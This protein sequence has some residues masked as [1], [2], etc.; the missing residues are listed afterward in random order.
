M[1]K[2][3]GL[4]VLA[5]VL[6][7]GML[8]PVAGSLGVISNRSGDTVSA[9][10]SQMLAQPPPAVTTITDRSGKPIAHLYDQNRVP[11]APNQIS[12]TMKA[13]IT[14]IEDRRFFDHEGVDWPGTMRAAASNRAS[15]QISQ[16]G[17]T[18]TQ[19][20]VKNYQ[21]HVLAADDPVKQAKA[22]EQTPARKMR[23]IRIALQLEKRLDKQ[24]IL[25]RYLNVVPFGN[26]TY[27]ISAAAQT[28]FATTPDKLSVPQ[29]ALLAG[30]VN[31][32]SALNPED[33][34]EEAVQ[35]RNTVIDS[36]QEQG[37]IDPRSADEA[38]AAPLELASPLGSVPNGCVGAGPAD[39][40]F[41]KYVINYLERAGFSEQQLEKGGYT[42]RTSLDEGATQAAK[43]AA[44]KEVPKNT[45]G[46]ANVMTVVEPGE[47]KHQV[48][49][50]V[51]NRDF[52]MEPDKGQTAYALPSGIAKFGA[53]SIYKTFT[54]AAGLE[55]G[56]GIK[57]V[58]PAPGNYTSKTYK[59]GTSPYTV[60]NAEG[61]KPG[62]RTLQDALATS[63]NTAFVALQERIGLGPVVDMATR[64]GMR[65]TMTRT[66]TSGQS[67]AANGS[68]GPT[69]AESV[70]ENNVGAFTLG[71]APTSPL[72]LGN[73][74][75]TLM[76]GGTWCPPTPIEQITDRSGKPVSITEAPCE[77]AVD[78]E[79]ANGMAAGMSKDDKSGGTSEQAASGA[80]WKRPVLGKT[81]TTESHQS[82][83]FIGATPQFAGSVLTFSDGGRPQGICDSTPPRLCGSNGNIYGGKVPA[84]TWY[85]GMK[86]IHEG[87][88]VLELPGATPRYSTGGQEPHV[89]DVVGMDA[90][91]ARARLSEAGYPIE[92]QPVDSENPQGTVSSQTP[93]G[94]ASPGERITVRISTG[95]VPTP[96]PEPPAPK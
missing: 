8:F 24:E 6:V 54:A 33:N 56:M 45:K 29:A 2:L 62:P 89:P 12:D 50:L 79:L 18:L 42:I 48:R 26:Q 14:S 49:A 95:H 38:R 34:P 41:C 37:R 66:N 70:L 75:A 20:Y 64:L 76:S 88:P 78:R 63:P 90:D 52:G 92:E 91:D 40:F 10:S 85:N 72:E 25:A 13:A 86:Q 96:A 16:G 3:F 30:M 55:Q 21:M 31:S 51:A 53:G 87:L 77:Q 58:I 27:G 59:N 83:G 39:G 93:R 82:A 11:V 57:D 47:D 73:V 9:I 65:Q 5:G 35:R 1:V 43:Q 22:V 80:G 4:C 84:R 36:M 60:G 69:Q 17:S 68:N 81:G 23:E 94:A 28:Y 7:A 71:Y 15:G 44:E 67:V 74:S 61:I 32:P 46:I 19:Q